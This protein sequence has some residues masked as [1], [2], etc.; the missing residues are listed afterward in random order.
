MKRQS[1]SE[2]GRGQDRWGEKQGS[3]WERSDGKTKTQGMTDTRESRQKKIHRK[4]DL[5]LHQLI[6]CNIIFIIMFSSNWKI[7]QPT[8]L[9]QQ[10][11]YKDFG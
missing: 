1:G 3:Q 2:Q 8:E 6:Q 11:S 9:T 5:L 4:Q 10:S 7:C